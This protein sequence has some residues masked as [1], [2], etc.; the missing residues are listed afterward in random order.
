MKPQLLGTFHFCEKQ[1]FHSPAA[2]ESL[3]ALPESNQKARHRALCF[4]SHPANQNSLCFSAVRGCSDSTSMYCFAIAAIH[5]RDPAGSFPPHLRCSAPRRRRLS[6]NPSIHGLRLRNL[7]TLACSGMRAKQTGA[8][9][10]LDLAFD[11]GSPLSGPSIAGFVD[12]ARRGAAMDRRTREQYMDVLSERP[13]K[14]EKR[15]EPRARNARG[16]RRGWILFGDF[17]LSIQE[18]V[19][20]STQSSGSSA[21]HSTDKSGSVSCAG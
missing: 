10:A 4:D 17:L 21:L 9:I 1:S 6:A 13:H 8:S 12:K 7:N 15:R 20:R 3:L 11:L 18:K 2:S 14:G 5:R 16:A 19:T